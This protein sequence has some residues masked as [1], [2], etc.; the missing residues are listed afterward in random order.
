MRAF[1][2]FQCPLR[3]CMGGGFD[4]SAAVPKG[5]SRKDAVKG[6]ATCE[7]KRKRSHGETTRCGLHVDFEVAAVQG[8]RAQAA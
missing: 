7:G 3:E 5:V 2:K 4:L 1:F 8:K 6:S